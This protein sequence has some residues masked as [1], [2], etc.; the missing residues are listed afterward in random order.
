MPNLATATQSTSASCL[1]T[2]L[3][4]KMSFWCA[5]VGLPAV[6]HTVGRS[7]R[8]FSGRGSFFVPTENSDTP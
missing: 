1:L 8:V 2:V 6:W 7:H 5:A 4:R 3:L